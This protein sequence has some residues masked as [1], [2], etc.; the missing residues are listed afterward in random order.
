MKI[1]ITY[2]SRYRFNVKCSKKIFSLLLVIGIYSCPSLVSNAA[3]MEG[4]SYQ[5]WCIYRDTL[6]K[7]PSLKVYYTF[8]K[9]SD[10]FAFDGDPEWVEGRWP[11]KQAPRFDSNSVFANPYNIENKNFTCEMW[12]RKNGAGGEQRLFFAHGRQNRNPMGI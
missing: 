5:N 10:D 2:N 11:E 7:D 1:N 4:I 6:K 9:E 3:D 12:I 8:E